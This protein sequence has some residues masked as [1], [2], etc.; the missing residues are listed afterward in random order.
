MWPEHVPHL[1]DQMMTIVR[2]K[3]A[4]DSCRSRDRNG[5]VC[6]HPSALH[7]NER[8][9]ACRLPINICECVKMDIPS[10]VMPQAYDEER[11]KRYME[12]LGS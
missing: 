6:G 2:G 12:S 5:H 9:R 11:A 1:F 10:E 3:S 4:N 7:M 8:E